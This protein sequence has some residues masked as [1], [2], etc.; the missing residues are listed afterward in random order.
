MLIR[1]KV[2]LRAV[3]AGKFSGKELLVCKEYITTRSEATGDNEIV[4]VTL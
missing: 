3:R 1:I 2:T 4:L